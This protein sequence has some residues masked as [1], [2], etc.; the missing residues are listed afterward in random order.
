MP[1]GFKASHDLRSADCAERM[2]YAS[3]N[4]SVRNLLISNTNNNVRDLMIANSKGK[5]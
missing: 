3:K 5:Q 1:S 4:H 2:S